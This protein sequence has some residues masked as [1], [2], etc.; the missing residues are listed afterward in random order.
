MA[1]LGLTATGAAA[2]TGSLP[3]PAQ[4]VV[5]EAVSHVGI[6]I[7]GGKSA[8]HRKDGENRKDKDEAPADETPGDDTGEEP[9][10]MSGVVKGIKDARTAESGPMGQEVCK[11]ASDGKCQSGAEHKGQ[12]GDDETTPPGAE[13]ANNGRGDEKN[14]ENGKPEDAPAKPDTPAGS[15]DTGA[16]NSGRTLP[17]GSGTPE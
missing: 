17:S 11:I 5:S 4:N 10:G 16:G 15:I 6:D 1:V 3:D 12:G 9:K 8:D 13:G 2:G 14:G 7:P